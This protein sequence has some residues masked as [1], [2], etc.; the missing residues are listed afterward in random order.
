MEFITFNTEIIN[1][2]VSGSIKNVGLFGDSLDRPAPPYVVVKSTT[3]E[4]RKLLHI[5]VHT[6]SSL[7]A[8]DVLDAY[9][10]R[11]L[12]ELLKEPLK[13]NG[14]T[15]TVYNTGVWGEPFIDEADNTLAMSREFYIPVI[16]F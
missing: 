16:N 15:V 4:N 12:P 8:Q 14:K 9:I 2:L 1:R 6:V 3:K 11:E 7:G 10:F 5:F 13:N